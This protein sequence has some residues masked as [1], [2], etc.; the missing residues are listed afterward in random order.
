MEKMNEIL[1]KLN[2]IQTEL[3]EQKATI[4]NN[5]AKVTEQVTQNF[6]KIL[7]E[8]LDLLEGKYDLL[9][10]TVD[11]QEKRLYILEK[12]FRERNLVFFGMDENEKSYLEL[13]NKIIQFIEEHLDLQLGSKDIQVVK[14]LGIKKDRPRPIVVTFT[15]LGT[16]IK[17]LKNKRM[18][19]DTQYYIK[20]DFPKNIL[21]KRRELQEQLKIEKDKGNKAIIKYDKLIILGQKTDATNS[22]KRNLYM[23]PESDSQNKPDHIAQ[24]AKKNKTRATQLPPHKISNSS[25][26]VVKPGILNFLINKNT[27][28]LE[29]KDTDL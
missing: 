16:K 21:E 11:T 27:N 17:L 8:K 5:G 29:N 9:K 15:T 18:L 13:E 1:E 20:E 2:N 10:E 26:G 25:E 6:N 28:R 7:D 22:K 19:N 23:S 14:R 24:A 4:E 12:Q 3:S